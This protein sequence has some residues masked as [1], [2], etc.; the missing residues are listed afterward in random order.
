MKIIIKR[1]GE[2]FDVQEIESLEL[3]DMQNMVGGLIECISVGDGIDMWIN[4]MGKL[5]HLPLNMALVSKD[6]IVLDTVQGDA[7]FAGT[8][9]Y[10]ETIGLTNEQIDN[11]KNRYALVLGFDEFGTGE[12]GVFDAF[13]LESSCCRIYN[14]S[15]VIE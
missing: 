3:S 1:V 11:I 12:F 14:E 5:E 9:G 6:G 10:G 13:E 4:D 7:F 2:S 8:D 15:E